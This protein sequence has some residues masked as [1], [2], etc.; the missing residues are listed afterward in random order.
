MKTLITIVL[1]ILYISAI[2]YLIIRFFYMLYVIKKYSNDVYLKWMQKKHW[3]ICILIF[4]FGYLYYSVSEQYYKTIKDKNENT[5]F[6][7]SNW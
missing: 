1:L 2:L 6:N 5:I 7:T 3:L 4:H